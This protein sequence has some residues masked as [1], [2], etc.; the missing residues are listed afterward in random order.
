MNDTTTTGT[1]YHWIITVQL[2]NGNLAQLSGTVSAATSATR[3]AIFAWAQDTIFEQIGTRKGSVVFFS[4]EPDAIDVP[5]PP[6]QYIGD[7]DD[8]FLIEA[9]DTGG[10]S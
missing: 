7:D 1:V 5:N 10:V 2:S 9:V 4:L 3:T 8:P 6:V